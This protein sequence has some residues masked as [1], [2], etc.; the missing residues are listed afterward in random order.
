MPPHTLKVPRPALW[1]TFLQAGEGQRVLAHKIAPEKGGLVP[2]TE[3]DE[4]ELGDADAKVHVSIPMWSQSWSSE[5]TIN[6]IT[7]GSVTGDT[8]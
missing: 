1:L 5:I 2:H 6:D 7:K 3:A 8:F 4:A